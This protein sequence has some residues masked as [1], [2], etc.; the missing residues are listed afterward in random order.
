MSLLK[1]KITEILNKEHYTF[2][3][4]ATYLHKSEEKLT[5]ELNN[6]TLEIKSLE[7]ISKVLRVPLYSF[8]RTEHVKLDFSQKPYYVNHLWTGDDTTKTREDLIQEIDFLKQII[9]LKEEQLSKSN[10]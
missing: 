4:L 5:E 1:S 3:D 10:S 6:N 7:E 2:A 9:A 8:F